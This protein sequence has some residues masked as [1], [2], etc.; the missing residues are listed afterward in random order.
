[1]FKNFRFEI[2]LIPNVDSFISDLK[3]QIRRDYLNDEWILFL[4]V[5][6][7][8]LNQLRLLF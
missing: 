6:F 4:D 1:M 7:L 5:L 8:I 3:L 2:S